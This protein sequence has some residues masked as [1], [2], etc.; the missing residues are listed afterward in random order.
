[1]CW[2]SAPWTACCDITAPKMGTL[3]P[4]GRAA[5]LWAGAS[6][7]VACAHFPIEEQGRRSNH[8]HGLIIFNSRQTVDWLRTMLAGGTEEARS[9]L[10]DWRDRVLLAVES[11]QSTCVAAAPLLM[12]TIP[13][14]IGLSIAEPGLF[15]EAE[16][17]RQV[18]RT[19]R[20][21]CSR[22]R[23]TKDCGTG[24]GRVEILSLV[25]SETPK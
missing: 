14:D 12:A 2:A 5:N 20:S 9:R 4:D 16:T 7:S 6:C 17:R 1:M 21:G 15:P 25:F 19:T 3:Y 22:P 23:E 10:R 13:E 11:M 8:G 18:R 24:G